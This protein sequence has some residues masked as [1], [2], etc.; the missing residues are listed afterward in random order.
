MG[1]PLCV[2]FACKTL[3]SLSASF[4]FPCLQNS[5]EKFLTQWAPPCSPRLKN[6]FFLLYMVSSYSPYVS[7]CSCSHLALLVFCSCVCPHSLEWRARVLG[8]LRSLVPSVMPGMDALTKCWNKRMNDVATLS[9]QRRNV[10]DQ[11][12]IYSGSSV[13]LPVRGAQLTVDSLKKLF[14]NRQ[15]LSSVVS[16]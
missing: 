9:F 5:A 3:F 4:H 1:F 7:P 13:P 12:R 6:W 14:L 11:L 8:L 16:S 15:Y 10:S 2:L